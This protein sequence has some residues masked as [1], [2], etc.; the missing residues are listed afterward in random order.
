LNFTSTAD[1]ILF[2]NLVSLIFREAERER[3]TGEVIRSGFSFV[4]R[5]KVGA[6][7]TLFRKFSQSKIQP[8]DVWSFLRRNLTENQLSEFSDI[9]ADEDW[10]AHGDWELIDRTAKAFIAKDPRESTAIFWFF[11]RNLC[12]S[13]R[14]IHAQL[15]QLSGDKL[16]L[17]SFYNGMVERIMILP[18]FDCQDPFSRQKYLVARVLYWAALVELYLRVSSEKYRKDIGNEKAALTFFLPQATNDKALIRSV[19]VFLNKQ[20]QIWAYQ[21]GKE[22]ITDKRFFEDITNASLSPRQREKNPDISKV[23]KIF[24]RWRRGSPLRLVNLEKFIDPLYSAKS[25][26][27]R[28]EVTILMIPI[29]NLFDYVQRQLL[30]QG[31]SNTEI[32]SMFK[33]YNRYVDLVTQAYERTTHN[34]NF[35]DYDIEAKL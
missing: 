33:E 22:K 29:I 18:G 9:F 14:E 20:K 21:C 10:S 7:S 6:D 17:T 11:L 5:R 2:N 19:E 31:L 4:L 16:V 26:T 27:L 30:M 24:Q 15:S 12:R 13:E 1:G 8:E 3:T 34:I 23:K 25:M 28:N 32:E 35:I